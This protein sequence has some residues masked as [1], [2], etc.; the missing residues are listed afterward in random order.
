M[1][2]Q[3]GF[4]ILAED[5]ITAL[6]HNNRKL[7]EERIGDS[8]VAKFI[9]LIREKGESQ[10]HVGV[11]VRRAL[12]MALPSHSRRNANL[13]GKIWRG[14]RVANRLGSPFV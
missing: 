4:Q 14:V 5:T 3:I 8:E 9:S 11:A 10:V 7:L 2:S 13:L 1:Q 6:V 12:A